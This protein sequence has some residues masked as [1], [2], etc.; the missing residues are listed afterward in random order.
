MVIGVECV[1]AGVIVIVDVPEAGASCCAVASCC[2]RIV[3]M[4]LLVRDAW[5]CR[6]GSGPS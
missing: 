4:A 3:G 1:D 5:G 2:F 6:E